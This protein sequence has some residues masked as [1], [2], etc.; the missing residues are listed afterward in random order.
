MKQRWLA[1]A[2]LVFAFTGLSCQQSAGSHASVTSPALTSP[3]APEPTPSLRSPTPPDAEDAQAISDATMLTVQ[4]LPTGWAGGQAQRLGDT[5]RPF[6]PCNLVGS[7]H[8]FVGTIASF[9]QGS[10]GSSIYQ[11]NVYFL[12]G[13]A[14][15]YVNSWRDALQRC[16]QFS[17]SQGT[18][19]Y[20]S[21]S[22]PPHGDELLSARVK[23][24]S[25]EN[26][27]SE[28]DLIL[29][30]RGNVVF[31]FYY[32]AGFAAPID[33]ALMEGLVTAIDARAKARLE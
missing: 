2:L 16:P 7:S 11:Q 26:Q 30:R 27:K 4:D 23:L 3:V 10:F 8:R 18:L 24:T 29:W 28:G 25:T 13:G 9:D 31:E 17:D 33:P 21:L 14:P 15:E 1:L 6:G 22:F 20:S 12:D 19:D 32:Q 5:S